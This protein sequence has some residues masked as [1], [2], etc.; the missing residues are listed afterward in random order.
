MKQILPWGLALGVLCWV[1][2]AAAQETQLSAA[3]DNTKAPLTVKVKDLNSSWR[4]LEV[5]GSDSAVIMRV[6]AHVGSGGPESLH[7]TKGEVVTIGDQTYLLAY[8]LTG[9]VVT[10]QMARAARMGNRG[11]AS[12]KLPADGTLQLS[13][14][15]LRTVSSLD[16]IKV[17]D[18][19]TDVESVQE[20]DRDYQSAS[21]SNL[22]QIGLGLQQYLMDYDE[23][24]PSMRSSQSMAEMRQPAARDKATVQQA[25]QPYTQSYEIFVHPKTKELYR[26]NLN[27][28]K[29]SLSDLG[30]AF[31]IVAFYE[32][33]PGADGQRAVLFLDGHVNRVNAARWNQLQVQVKPKPAVKAA[34]KV[35]GAA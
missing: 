33:S 22:R 15:N 12:T 25:L 7:Y 11:P 24:L 6:M 29:K 13:L 16:K 26:P 10:P 2:P 1:H 8:R 35:V 9:N 20:S 5:D 17:F 27:I 23:V 30:N 18:P 28:S 3:L 14:L 34:A 32:A 31:Y 21:V 19:K 4:K